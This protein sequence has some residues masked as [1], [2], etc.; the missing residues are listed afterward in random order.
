MQNLEAQPATGTLAGHDGT[1]LF[2][3]HF[4]AE[5]E[6]R[7]GMVIVHGLCEH[8]GRYRR[9]ARRLSQKGISVTAFDNRGH[10]L[11]GGK[12]GHV[13]RFSD[14]ILDLSEV[15]GKCRGE[16]SENTP[17]LLLGHSLGG[18]IVLNFAQQYPELISAVTASSPALATAEEIPRAKAVPGK[19]MS[20][21]WPSLTFDNGLVPQHLSHDE[22][23]VQDYINDPLVHR[24]VSARLFTEMTDAMTTT[25]RNAAL[26]NLPVLMQVAGADRLVDPEGSREFFNR[27]AAEDKTLHYYEGMFHEIYNEEQDRRQRVIND[28]EDW[29]LKHIK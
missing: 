16:L 9:L 28:L 3:R 5:P 21:I 22:S 20:A 2:F 18:L 23:V 19:I 25:F 17:L 8:S 7:A 14:Y 11:S 27:V 6:T 13:S 29:L 15:L 4:P 26:I 24:R 10:G 1:K 12:R